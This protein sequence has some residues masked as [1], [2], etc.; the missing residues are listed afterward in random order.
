MVVCDGLKGPPDA[1]EATWPQAVT[2]PCVIHL[3]RASFC[4][5]GRAALGRHDQ[6]TTTGLHRTDRGSR[7]EATLHRV[8]RRLGARYPAVIRLWTTPGP[9]SCRSWPSGP[10]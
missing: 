8:R 1:I 6:G 9:S 10:V 7:R 3:L 4:Y 5:A 2:Q